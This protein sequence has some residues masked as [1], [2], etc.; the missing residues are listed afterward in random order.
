MGI[1]TLM[2]F[3]SEIAQPEDLSKVGT[4]IVRLVAL[5]DFM[6]QKSFCLWWI[7]LMFPHEYFARN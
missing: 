6:S 1:K 4:I 2:N 7:A 3:I 5:Q